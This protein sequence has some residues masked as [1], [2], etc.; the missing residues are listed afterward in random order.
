MFNTIAK[1]SALSLLIAGSFLFSA[2]AFAAAPGTGGG[3]NTCQ[4]D[5][6]FERGPDPSVAML[7]APNGPY[8]VRS[9]NVSRFTSGFGGGTIHYPTGQT[10]PMAGIV[11]IPGFLSGEGSVDWWGPKLASYGFVV[12]TIATNSGWDQPPSRAR[13]LNAALDYLV[14]Q[15]TDR[16]SPVNGMIDTSRLGAVGWSMGGG[17]TLRVATEG[18]LQAAIPLTP[19]DTSSSQ[20]RNV[21]APTLIFACSADTVAP[22]AMHASPFYRALPDNISKA[23]IEIRGGSHFCANGGGLINNNELLGRLGVS[24]MKLHLDKDERYK[25][26]IC[27]PRHESDRSISEYRGNCS[28]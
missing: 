27:G 21:K 18:R 20:F 10:E 7:E 4:E 9:T 13:Q 14:S 6:G 28:N 26:F 1:K 8:T 5:C 15:N 16:S 2:G 12:M 22:V 25:Q 3:G 11:V 23:F 24:W 17:G 19:W